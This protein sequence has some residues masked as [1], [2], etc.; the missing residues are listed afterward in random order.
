VTER[1]PNTWLMVPNDEGVF[2]GSAVHAEVPCVHP[3][4]AVLDLD[5]HPERAKEA[6]TRIRETC[7][8]WAGTQRP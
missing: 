7:M 3:V 6:A 5:H 1:G 4:Q 8:N 2:Q